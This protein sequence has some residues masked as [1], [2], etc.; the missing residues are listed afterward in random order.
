MRTGAVFALIVVLLF[1]VA[2]CGD[3]GGDGGEA[4]GSAVQAEES[5]GLV[6]ADEISLPDG[7]EMQAAVSA[8]DVAAITDK[9]MKV[10]P[11]AGSAA[12][13]GYPSCEYMIDGVSGS[14]VRFSARV[15]GGEGV[16]EV[17]HQYAVEGS[18]TDVDGLGDK[19]H[20]LD[21]EGG[22]F[23]IVALK[24]DSRYEIRWDPSHYSVDK[25]EMGLELMTVL[26]SNVYKP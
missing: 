17:L 16:Y 20:T 22:D 21:V 26:L 24:G 1:G 7:W 23:A 4:T 3:S 19:A 25:A 8:E 14:G 11:L 10:F 2:G 12:Q 18:I 6:L 15:E 9:E 13:N 5:G